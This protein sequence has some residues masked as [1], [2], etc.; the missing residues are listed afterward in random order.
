MAS[1]SNGLSE[2]HSRHSEMKPKRMV[3]ILSFLELVSTPAIRLPICSGASRT[4]LRYDDGGAEYLWSD[5]YPHGSAVE[6]TP[7]ISPWKITAVLL[8]GFVIYKGE[9]SFLIEIRGY[10]FNLIY[11]SSHSIS[12]DFKNATLEWT[13]APLLNVI[14]RGDF[15]SVFTPCWIFTEHS[16]GWESTMTQPLKEASW[17]IVMSRG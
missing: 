3:A 2:F 11:K 1:S 7:Q 12:K 17:S 10:D 4:L 6:F 13:T 14:V 15:S 9:K 8:Y 5:Y 16:S